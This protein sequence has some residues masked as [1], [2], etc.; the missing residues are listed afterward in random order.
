[1]IHQK[2]L[3]L[4]RVS[5]D[6]ERQDYERQIS[7]LTNVA[8][9]K[10]WTIFT[11]LKN[12][13]SAT[14]KRLDQR[15]EIEILKNLVFDKKIDLVL[16]TELTRLGRTAKEILEVYRFLQE[17]GIGIYIHSMSFYTQSNNPI[18]QSVN[19]I[20][21]TIMAE[22]SEQE[23]IHLRQRIKSGQAEAKRK[24]K[25]IGRAKGRLGNFAKKMETPK[26]QLA[27]KKIKQGLSLRD[28]AAISDISVNTVRKIKDWIS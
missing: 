17:N 20:I 15:P 25:H 6:S 26:Y 7:D 23:I 24:G 9:F 8:N 3:L 16:V 10:N 27:A 4:V 11:I 5:S 19:N 1:M 28:V 13:I 18:T 12:K 14:K 2:A 22:I 21:V